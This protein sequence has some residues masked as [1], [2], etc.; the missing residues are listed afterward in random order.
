M[1]RESIRKVVSGENLGEVEMEM[2]MQ[3]IMGGKTTSAQIAS[4]ITAL[5]I[6]GETVDEIVGAARAM[7]ANGHQRYRGGWDQYL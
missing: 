3:E 7:R 1:I 4:F 5:R 2:T 6:K